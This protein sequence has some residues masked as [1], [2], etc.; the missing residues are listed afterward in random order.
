MEYFKLYGI[1][2]VQANTKEIVR[3]AFKDTSSDRQTV[4]FTPNLQITCRAA[5]G[6]ELLLLLKEADIILP[7]GAGVSLLFRINGKPAPKRITGIDTAYTLMQ[8]AAKRRLSVFFLGGKRGTAEL[9]KKRL[10]KSIC[11]LKICGF[12]HG[13]FDKRKN[14]PENIRVIRKIQRSDADI[15]FVCFGFPEQERW[16]CENKELLKNV[17]IFMGLGGSLDVWS[18]KVRRAPLPL[19]ALRLEWLWR[20]LSEPKRFIRLLNDTLAP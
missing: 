13:Y 4:I 8:Y 10:C 18:G 6:K 5:K 16:I 19:R 17:K 15:L 1:K 12:H 2:F 11:G 7:D 9:A 3:N 14:S 20:C